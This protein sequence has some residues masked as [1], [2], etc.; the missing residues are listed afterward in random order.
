MVNVIL[1]FA[2]CFH[3]CYYSSMFLGLGN[4][5]FFSCMLCAVE[6]NQQRSLCYIECESSQFLLG[7]SFKAHQNVDCSSKSERLFGDFKLKLGTRRGRVFFNRCKYQST[8]LLFDC[9]STK[10]A[11][12]CWCTASIQQQK[13]Q[14]CRLF[15]SFFHN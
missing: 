14:T 1:N 15:F 8:F 2:N 13:H 11:D 9:E 10:K 7:I 6:R 3:Q 12:V 5:F 4:Q